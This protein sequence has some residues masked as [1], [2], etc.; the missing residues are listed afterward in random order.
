MASVLV[1][2]ALANKPLSGGEAWVRMS[3]VRGLRN[4]GL[5]VCFAEEIRSSACVDAQG[6]PVPFDDS[7]NRRFFEQTMAALAPG[8]PAALICD[9]GARTAGMPL[10]DLVDRAREADLLVNISGHLALDAVRSGPRRSA[11]VDVDPAFTQIWEH[12]HPGS[13]R[14]D[15]HTSYFTVGQNVGRPSCT[16]PTAGIDWRPL[17]PPVTLGDWPVSAAGAVNR[18]TT[19]STWRSALGTLSLDDVTFPGKHHEWRRVIELPRRSAHAFE[20]ALDIHPGDGADREALE[21]SGWHL[22]DPRG[23][24]GDPSSFRAYVQGSGAEFSVAHGAYVQ[25]AS[26][27]LS[28]RTVRY[29]ASGKP[30]VVQDTGL[31]D[32]CPTGEGLVTF[33]TVDDAA[34]ACDAVVRDYDRHAQAARALAEQ[35][36][37]SDRVI[38]RFLDEAGVS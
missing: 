38:A 8:C 10:T 16:I 32:G 2:G 28:D 31:A 20:I 25:T 12:A 4:L 15:G 3:W 33:T 23:A 11:Y 36:F 5:D 24:A 26:G 34:A 6:R 13:A 19:I 9:D 22:R 21:R 37:D 18:F 35:R 29:L 7:L 14:L 30:A 27:W 17:P 1:S